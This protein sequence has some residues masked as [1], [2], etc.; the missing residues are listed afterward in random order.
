MTSKRPEVWAVIHRRGDSWTGRMVTAQGL[1]TPRI[2]FTAEAAPPAIQLGAQ[3]ELGLATRK[4]A[5]AVRCGAQVVAIEWTPLGI[6]ISLDPDE[7][8][9]FHEAIPGLAENPGDRRAEVRVFPRSGH[10]VHVPVRLE[11][12]LGG[13]P[14]M[15]RVTDAST[16]G[17][18]LLFP[19]AA[20]ER[21]CYSRVLLVEL[22]SSAGKRQE[23]ECQVRNRTLVEDGVRYGVEFRI[24][25]E[26]APQPFEPLWDCSACGARGLLAASH[27]RCPEC[28]RPRSGPTRIPSRDGRLSAAIHPY[29]GTERTCRACGSKWSEH[30]KFCAQ[31]GLRL[32]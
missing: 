10:G 19:Y 22:E 24:A 20:E 6:E 15:A 32:G 28:G 11:D 5:K 13:K 2:A 9:L 1:D 26:P 16:G 30:A 4:M 27:L 21:L 25:R 31:C 8:E 17:L 3:V 7:P 14:L 18:G 23:V 12:D 29:L